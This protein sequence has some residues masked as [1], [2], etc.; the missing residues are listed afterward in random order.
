MIRSGRLRCLGRDPKKKPPGFAARRLG[1]WVLDYDTNA[2][3]EL[4]VCI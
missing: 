1:N 4:G 3:A 2:K